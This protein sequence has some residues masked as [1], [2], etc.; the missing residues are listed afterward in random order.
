LVI[1]ETIKE[2]LHKIRPEQDSIFSTKQQLLQAILSFASGM[3]LGIMAKYSDTV[4][5]NG[6]SGIFWG[7]VSDITTRLGIWV[8]LASVI[9]G[10]SR[11]PRMGALKV[12]TFFAGMLLSYY[13]YSMWLFGFFPAHYF[14]RWGMIA[15]A[16]PI[17]A[18]VVWFG[19]GNGWIAAFCAAMPVSLLVAQGWPVFYM[20]PG[21]LTFGFECLAGFILF[22][23]LPVNKK[24]WLRMVPFVLI[25][26]MIIRKS[27]I[28]S[29][30]F[31][32]M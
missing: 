32:G 27:N 29:Y 24:Q 16:S 23:L 25:G 4:P 15:L 6:V 14:M 8:L 10:W 30:L 19:R 1:K 28:L 13:L 2:T 3:L 26:T 5:F 20:T 11:N 17:A 21:T 18:Y 22:L 9:A 31:G 7:V 12:F